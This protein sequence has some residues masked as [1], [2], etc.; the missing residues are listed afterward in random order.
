MGFEDEV[1]RYA[2]FG[3]RVIQSVLEGRG[4]VPLVSTAT[5]FPTWW[6]FS[7]KLPV[8]CSDGSPPVMTTWQAGKESAFS[9]IC[10]SLISQNDSWL[11]S[12]KGHRRLQPER[13]MKMEGVP[14]KNPSPC[15]E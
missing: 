11:V 4:C 12:Q 9:A 1:L 3:D 10:S 8:S 15:S 13:R 5:N 6:S 14:V 7:I 2:S